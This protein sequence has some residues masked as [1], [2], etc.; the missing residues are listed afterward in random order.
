MDSLEQMREWLLSAQPVLKKLNKEI[1]DHEH[2]V[3][4]ISEQLKTAQSDSTRKQKTIDEHQEKLIKLEEE[5]DS[6]KAKYDEAKKSYVQ[7]QKTI[8]EYQEKLIKLE[9]ERD[10][11]KMKYD[12]AKKCYVQGHKDQRREDAKRDDQIKQLRR[13][14][15]DFEERL[16][17]AEATILQA[18][19]E[20]EEARDDVD[21]VRKGVE[22]V[23]QAA[24]ELSKP[25]FSAFNEA[26]AGLL[27]KALDNM[28]ST[29]KHLLKAEEGEEQRRAKRIRLSLKGATSRAPIALDD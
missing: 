28:R 4:H 1:Q 19:T 16:E 20:A 5:R 23:K 7:G 8:D 15:N 9:E 27:G 6:F 2:Q 12:E 22:E 13:K 24:A 21:R 3:L 26:T 25:E 14:C 10:S 17:A 11:L 29:S 18:T